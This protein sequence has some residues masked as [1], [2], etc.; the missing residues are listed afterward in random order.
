MRAADSPGRERRR[1]SQATAASSKGLQATKKMWG[2]ESLGPIHGNPRLQGTTRPRNSRELLAEKGVAFIASMG[3]QTKTGTDLQSHV[4]NE[5]YVAQGS[6]L[7]DAAE[8]FSAFSVSL[9]E[10]RAQAQLEQALKVLHQR[11][12]P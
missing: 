11:S 4:D 3:G 12:S 1:S 6:V 8:R 5:Q 7:H 10:R 2:R 9:D